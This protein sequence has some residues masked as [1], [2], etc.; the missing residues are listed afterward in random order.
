MPRLIFRVTAALVWA[1]F[2]MSAAQ[3]ARA[4]STVL[5]GGPFTQNH[6]PQYAGQG[7]GQAVLKDG[8][9]AGGGP[10]GTN[11]NELGITAT[12]TGTAPFAG[13]GKGPY[14]TNSVLYDAPINN[15]A[16]YHYLGF[17]A[18]AQGGGLLAY[19]AGG[20]ASPLPLS[21]IVNGVTYQFPFVTDGIVGPTSSAVG[22]A[23]CWNNGQG[24]LLKDCGAPPALA[25]ADTA[26]LQALPTTILA[27]TNKIRVL[28]YNIANHQ[29]APPVDYYLTGTACS[30]DSGSCFSALG[31]LLFWHITPQTIWDPRWWG[32]YEDVN[33]LDPPATTV[34]TV[35]AS[36][37]VVISSTQAGFNGFTALDVGKRIVITQSVVGAANNPTYA[38]SILSI[39]NTTHITV[40]TPCPTASSNNTQVVYYGHDDAAAANAAIAYVGGLPTTNTSAQPELN[41]NGLASGVFSAPV[42][43]NGQITMRNCSEV[44]LGS[45][46]L[47]LGSSGVI[48]VNGFYSSLRECVAD[49]AFLPV[50]GIYSNSNGTLSIADSRAKNWLGSAT[51][52]TN[53]TGSSTVEAVIT[54][55]WIDT[56]S[57][58][59]SF[60]FACTLHVTGISSGVIQ[61]GQ[62]VYDSA[63]IPAGTYI[64]GPSDNQTFGKSGTYM[65][66][67]VTASPAVGSSGSP[68]AMSTLGL[69]VAVST[70]TS[71]NQSASQPSPGLISHG[72]TAS[73]IADRTFIVGCFTHVNSGDPPTHVVL[74]KAPGRPFTNASLNFYVDSNG[75]YFGSGAGLTVINFTTDQEEFSG[76]AGNNYG[77]SVYD[78]S[79]GGTQFK[80]RTNAFQG[81][82][83][84]V[85][86]PDGGDNEFEAPFGE[87]NWGPTATAC[88]EVDAPGLLVMDG[89]NSVEFNN[90]NIGGMIQVFAVNGGPNVTIQNPRSP[91]NTGSILYA[92]GNLIWGYTELANATINRFLIS[93]FGVNAQIHSNSNNQGVPGALAL[94]T[95]SVGAWN[96][97]AQ[98][99]N[100]LYGNN[101]VMIPY[102]G[103]LGLI[104]GA[105]FGTSALQSAQTPITAISGSYTFREPDC[106]NDFKFTGSSTFTVTVPPNLGTNISQGNPSS[107][108]HISLVANISSSGTLV[109]GSGVTL[110]VNG[111]ATSPI[112]LTQNRGYRLWCFG[113]P[114]AQSPTCIVGED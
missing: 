34:T 106:G 101:N 1:A 10:A 64:L 99:L 65:V 27:L 109:A 84:Y 21:F 111:T 59:T 86:G 93:P 114:N 6:L 79:G 22:D 87:V 50:N 4:Q 62:V 107:D 48:E 100:L 76:I 17:S 113:N 37:A 19:G 20:A 71:A 78:D 61:P 44:A 32:A 110:L 13:Q 60:G 24:T 63:T 25:V 89:A 47:P 104:Q 68:E 77:A 38:S 45:T 80:G 46:N 90:A 57:S 72:N 83:L 91:I 33:K 39:Q 28:T 11:P 36:C 14:G 7:N 97:T 9:G 95:G 112:T 103:P 81:A 69:D 43:M 54:S 42:N 102:G 85:V 92:P 82:A 56:C 52:P 3:P 5:Q 105:N 58:G 15:P 70:C 40:N 49:S 73:N 74:N 55:A 23:S 53:F 2:F 30:V 51:T 8:G 94:T 31:G 98:Q 75:L 18:N 41:F 96:L 88:C 26:A 12:G 67:N 29:N 66:Y 108:C 35:A 16:G